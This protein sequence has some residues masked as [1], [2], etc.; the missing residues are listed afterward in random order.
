MRE[1]AEA[2]DFERAAALRNRLIL[3][4]QAGQGSAGGDFAG[5]QRQQPGA[6]GIGSQHPKPATP[7]DWKRPAKPDPMTRGR[8]R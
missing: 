2:Q 1:A 8:S 6:M 7:R 4:R 5:L 3:L